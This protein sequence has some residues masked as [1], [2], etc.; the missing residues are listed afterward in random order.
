MDWLRVWRA[1]R[2]SKHFTHLLLDGGKLAVPDERAGAFLNEYANAIARGETPKVVELKTPVFRLFVDL[3]FKEPASEFSECLVD[4]CLNVARASFGETTE[5]IVMRNDVSHGVHLV[6]PDVYV[7]PGIA[8]AFRSEVL[9]NSGECATMH[10]KIYDK[11]VYGPTGLRMPYSGKADKPGVYVPTE[12]VS[13]TGSEVRSEVIV[14]S[15]AAGLRDVLKRTSIR[16]PFASATQSSL[17]EAATSE[18]DSSCSRAER[19]YGIPGSVADKVVACL[20]AC[21]RD[22]RITHVQCPA[23]DVLVLKTDSRVC[24]NLGWRA[25]NSNT[26]YFVLH[27]TKQTVVQRCYCRCETLEHRVA[28]V[29]C[30]DYASPEFP[31]PKGVVHAL[32]GYAFRELPEET[33]SPL[34]ELLAKTRPKLKKTATKPKTTP[35]TK[36]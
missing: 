14:A 18:E 23:A 33:V 20:P 4:A 2:N 13:V 16:A 12:R 10:E 9:K 36:K 26:V 15:T 8:L 11:C 25:H 31:V 28:G 21:F 6:F 5:M 27:R 24:G 22:S 32:F 35:A 3:D 34:R 30:K 29:M 17:F 7:T 1:P 19:V